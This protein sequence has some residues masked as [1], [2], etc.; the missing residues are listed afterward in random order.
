MTNS[1]RLFEMLITLGRTL[2]Q[3]MDVHSLLVSSESLDNDWSSLPTF[4]SFERRL[5]PQPIPVRRR[6]L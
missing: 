5:W 2:S 1:I 3:I 4:G 6:R